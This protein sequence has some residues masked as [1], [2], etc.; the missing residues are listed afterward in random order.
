MHGDQ[1]L[2]SSVLPYF[3]DSSF[4]EPGV[5]SVG[6]A[7]WLAISQVSSCLPPQSCDYRFTQLYLA[8]YVVLGAQTLAIILVKS[9]VTY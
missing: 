7:S 4:T 9:A 3:G 6:Q 1:R 2:V 5:H 8:S